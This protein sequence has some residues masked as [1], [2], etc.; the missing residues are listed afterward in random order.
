VGVSKR[1]IP[2]RFLAVFTD[3][4]MPDFL[5]EAVFA[6]SGG[7]LAMP[8]DIYLTDSPLVGRWHSS[9]SCFEDGRSAATQR[10]RLPH[11]AR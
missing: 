7:P 2:E 1:Q 10:D 6:S 9:T 11:N 5:Q 3:A 8:L 4:V